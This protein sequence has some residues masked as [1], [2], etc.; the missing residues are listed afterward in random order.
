MSTHTPGP[1]TLSADGW[2]ESPAGLVGRFSTDGYC[3]PRLANMDLILAA[4]ELYALVQKLVAA[5]DKPT[6]GDELALSDH[7]QDP[8]NEARA[9]IVKATQGGAA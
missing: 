4:P 5:W 9:A 3:T 7:M 2:I 1:W 8:L 6:Y